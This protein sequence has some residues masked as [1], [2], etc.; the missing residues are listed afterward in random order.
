MTVIVG[1]LRPLATIPSPAQL[2]E[3]LLSAATIDILYEED[4]TSLNIPYS[5]S[6]SSN[7]VQ[8]LDLLNATCLKQ[9]EHADAEVQRL[10]AQCDSEKRQLRVTSQENITSLNITCTGQNKADALK[11]TSE[12]AA[13]KEKLRLSW[14]E[15]LASS[16]ITCKEQLEEKNSEFSLSIARFNITHKENLA[17][18]NKE[19]AECERD[20]SNAYFLLEIKLNSTQKHLSQEQDLVAELREDLRK[21]EQEHERLQQDLES[22]QHHL[23]LIKNSSKLLNKVLRQIKCFFVN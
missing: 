15:K 10:T 5:S 21:E 1:Y 8:R 13:E 11:L 12:C 18:K 16:N 4:S 6:P 23:Q 22:L 7:C 14:Q 19:L 20:A 9:A 3:E 2:I 17:Q